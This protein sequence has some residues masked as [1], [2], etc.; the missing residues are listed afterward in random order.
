M[1]PDDEMTVFSRLRRAVAD[2][3]EEEAVFAFEVTSDDPSGKASYQSF[4]DWADDVFAAGMSLRI[5]PEIIGR[6]KEEIA[7]AFDDDEEA[8]EG[9]GVTTISVANIEFV[10]PLFEKSC[11][12]VRS[13]R[14]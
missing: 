3:V 9:R 4:S 8:F 6:F 12:Q 2:A 14:Y 10:K 13:G 5:S 7:S 11:C 1:I